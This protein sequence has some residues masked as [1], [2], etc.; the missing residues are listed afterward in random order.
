MTTS[1]RKY[2]SPNGFT[3]VELIVV[4]MVISLTAFVI[5]LIVNPEDVKRKARDNSRISDL[6]SL[7]QALE[8]YAGDHSNA[9]PDSGAKDTTRISNVLPSGSS[10]PLANSQ[11]QGW[12]KQDISGY[13][14]KLFQDPLNTGAYVYRYRVSCDGIRYKLDAVLEYYTSKMSDDG[15][16]DS[17][18]YEVGTATADNPINMSAGSC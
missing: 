10:G 13:L 17:T 9:L 12:V 6:L 3:L 11:G 16:Q 18:H 2:Y 14:P 5:I 4:V 8:T 15:G 7:S 1:K